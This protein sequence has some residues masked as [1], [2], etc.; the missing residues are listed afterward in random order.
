[1]RAVDVSAPTR[2]QPKARSGRD[3][4]AWWR[5]ARFGLFIHWGL[6]ALPAGVW[7]GKRVPY[8]GEWLMFR[9]KVPV[10]T[11]SKLAAQ[12]HPRRWDA[13]AVVR[14]A[15]E[16]GMGY[17]VITAKHHDGFAMYHSKVSP[18]NV[19]DASPWRHDPMV[20]LARECRRQGVKLCFYYS[21]DLDW[22]HPDGAWNEWDYEKAKKD[23]ERYLQEK[24]YPQLTELLTNYGPVGMIWFDTPLTISREQSAAIRRHV[25]RLQP[26]CLVSGRIGHGLGDYSLPRDNFLPPGRLKGDWE[27]CATL[28]HTWGFKRHDHA[29]KS[30]ANLITTLVD[31]TSKGSNYLLN[32]GPDANGVVP[33]P[34][35]ARLR[36]MGAWL[37]VNGRAIQ[38]A[39]PSPFAYEFPWGRI[40]TRGRTLYLH[41]FGKPP[42]HFQLRGLRTRVSAIAPLAS[43][44]QSF[45]F[46]QTVEATTDVP[47][48]TIDFTGLRFKKPVTVIGVTLTGAPEVVELPLQQPDRT[49]TLIG[50]MA[51]VGTTAPKPAMRMGGNGLT[52]NWRSTADF[53]EWKFV[54][55]SPGTYA[56][57][58]VT[59][60]QHLEPWSGGHTLRLTC[61]GQ[62]LRKVTRRDR[63]LPN[64]R[65]AYYPQIA[66]RFGELT[67]PR[68][69]TYTLRLR[70][71][72]MNLPKKNRTLFS[73]GG[74]QF[75]E[76]QLTP[77]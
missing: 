26:Q 16:A 67:F 56:V 54:I 50:P 40:T 51:R 29:W 47:V 63:V 69:G 12:F 37:K 31:L 57:D 71:D 60:H 70:P 28:N 64:L 73:D 45:A 49:V 24:V 10:A 66:T 5:D 44:R 38:G 3:D 9:E 61:D 65:S 20:D 15:K 62:T 72:R 55:L 11:Y 41:F 17:L 21:Q 35:V 39:A 53:L 77:R 74:M 59:T 75:S 1:M 36:A 25:K 23:T 48:L 27:T 33:A 4:L 58:V 2:S 42:R 19:V 8:I 52:E 76:I 6:Y 7:K 14:L 32:I 46:R 13:A 22:H 68:A 34:S 18:Y 43:P 30:A